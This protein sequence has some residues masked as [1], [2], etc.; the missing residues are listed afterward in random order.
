MEIPVEHWN[1]ENK[2]SHSI[3]RWRS[4]QVLRHWATSPEDF[5]TKDGQYLSSEWNALVRGTSRAC[6]AP[7]LIDSV[8]SCG[9]NHLQSA[10]THLPR[11]R[12]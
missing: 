9:T 8:R 12:P 5:Q 11:P 4:R 2:P 10:R 3:N 7:W 6:H 1:C